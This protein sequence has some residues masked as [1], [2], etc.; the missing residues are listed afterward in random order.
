MTPQQTTRQRGRWR[1]VLIAL[2]PPLIAACFS[3]YGLDGIPHNF[4]RGYPHGLGVAIR[5]A[6]VSG[7]ISGLPVLGS[8]ASINLRN[9]AGASYF[10]ALF[11]ALDDNPYVATACVAMLHAAVVTATAQNLARRIAGLPAGF[12]AGMLAA[13]SLWGN[14]VSRGAWLQGLLEPA[15][16]LTA[17]LLFNS[18]RPSCAIGRRHL[19]AALA[20]VALAIQTYLT[21]FGLLA[22]AALALGLR[23]R[24]IFAPVSR[25]AV[26][27]GGGMCAA[28]LAMIFWALAAGNSGL[29][30]VVNNPYLATTSPPL[31][32]I[33]WDPLSHTLRLVSGR[34]Y[35]NT[36]GV[37]SAA[38][39]RDRVS[40]GQATLLD[41]LFAL[42]LLLALRQ[43]RA[44]P[45]RRLLLLIS[46]LTLPILLTFVIAN[47]IARSWDVHVFDLILGAPAIYVAAA[48]PF[49]RL[50]IR[51]SARRIANWT[52]MLIL[53]AH[54]AISAVNLRADVV[55]LRSA[56][57]LP[58]LDNIRLGEAA[59]LGRAIRAQCAI[60]INPQD[61][62]WLGSWIGSVGVIRQ[63]AYRENQ[64]GSI[65]A[66]GPTGACLAAA[67]NGV[68]GIE[69]FAPDRGRPTHTVNIGWS[70]TRF[71]APAQAQSGR[72]ITIT[73]AWRVDSLSNEPYANWYVQ[74]FIKLLDGA[75]Q[76]LVNVDGAPALQGYGWRVG[77]TMVSNVTLTLP[78]ALPEGEYVLEASLFD[79]NL[80]RNAVY[81]ALDAPTAPIVALRAKLVI[82]QN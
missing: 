75:G 42:G 11:G 76:T 16:A 45:D 55:A 32:G 46:W 50:P 31:Q 15:A 21:A 22:Q 7:H 18:L 26:I 48:L 24:A 9:P 71:E 73:Q 25:R 20:T 80:K 10:W 30:D 5:E 33:N 41:G 40:D 27:M 64:N 3:L 70:L 12:A 63:E 4:D 49:G 17:W 35:E 68:M 74:P 60:L 44:G 37:A 2:T 65:A 78:D 56:P 67:R 54:S 59:R 39:W 57:T 72:A 19:F 13:T 62:I 66:I 82:S 52:L 61:P 47:L 69:T 43:L 29:A 23:G 1:V 53:L 8:I 79:P 51:D 77:E 81:F 38:G 6:L 14:W 58:S 28:S 34:D 36:F